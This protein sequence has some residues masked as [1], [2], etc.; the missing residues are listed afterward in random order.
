MY[1][2]LL[3]WQ[4]GDRI[5]QDILKEKRADYGRLIVVTLSRQ[6]SWIKAVSR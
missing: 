2:T 4:I 6:L 5:R 1:I 3:Y